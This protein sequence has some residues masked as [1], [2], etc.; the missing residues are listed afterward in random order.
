MY[1][2]QDVK[3]ILNIAN[4]S[5]GRFFL[6]IEADDNKTYQ[7]KFNA[8]KQKS[9]INEFISNFIGKKINAPVLDGGFFVFTEEQINS[10]FIKLQNTYPE[11]PP[12]PDMSNIKNYTFFGIEWQNSLITLQTNNELEILL[13]KVGNKKDFFSLYAYD[14]YLKNYDRH[15][16]NHLILKD[17]KNKPSQYCLIDG[18]RI[19]GSLD[20]SG[21]TELLNNFSCMEA[22]G[23][24]WH[25]Y[26]YSLVTEESYIFVLEFS[27]EIDS[28]KEEDIQL[29]K[30]LLS[31][32]YTIDKIEYDKI[33]HYLTFRKKDFYQVCLKNATCFPKIEQ[34]RIL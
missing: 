29:M 26:L 13:E 14:Q 12:F 34:T 8:Y 24:D 17:G 25:K 32:I 18:D 19:F 9:N 20:W 28:I 5:D 6:V 3:R 4:N 16:G 2:I 1:I 33:A 15:I 31:Y 11:N 7:I 22:L 30:N 23:A 21:I 27:F 10:I